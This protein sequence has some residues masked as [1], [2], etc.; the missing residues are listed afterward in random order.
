MFLEHNC[1]GLEK[2]MLYFP[3]RNKIS[4]HIDTFIM[5]PPSLN[6]NNSDP[7]S[8]QPSSCKPRQPLETKDQDLTF[9]L[10]LLKV[11]D[12]GRVGHPFILKGVR[13]WGSQD[14]RLEV[15][16]GQPYLFLLCLGGL[17]VIFTMTM[18]TI[19]NWTHSRQPGPSVNL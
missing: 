4:T 17:G 18:W 10:E 9:N 7:C 11:T 2:S 3:T 19:V 15:M 13:A 14:R 6:K 5:S 12:R 16:G 8:L 1:F